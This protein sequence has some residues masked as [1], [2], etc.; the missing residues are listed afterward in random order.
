MFSYAIA[1]AIQ[2]GGSA[3]LA[4][5]QQ[6]KPSWR[7]DAA[8]AQ[9]ILTRT[10]GGEPHSLALSTVPGS[11]RYELSVLGK[12]THDRAT[13]TSEAVGIQLDDDRPVE[14]AASFLRVKDLRIIRATG[15]DE[16]LARR[17]AAADTA[18]VTVGR[19]TIGPMSIHHAGKALAAL[20]GC[21]AEQLIEWGADAAQFEP[22]G[23]PARGKTD[24][25]HW[26]A[27]DEVR[28]ALAGRS[29]REV[30]LIL[31]VGATRTGAGENCRQ[32]A[33][34]MDEQ[35]AGRICALLNGRPLF[36]PGIDPVG[37]PVAGVGVYRLQ[38]IT[39]TVTTVSGGP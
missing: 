4:E 12:N 15:L 5:A 38:V 34:A 14:L 7:I 17:F 33:G 39:R 27:D 31:A 23:R 18:S 21:V 8:P 10:L 11:F 29:S 26:I 20:D 9:C 35:M 22:G 32:V 2:T 19:A 13:G 28:A 3:P 37:Q 16:A 6:L 25:E 24:Y 30:N 36:T 1:L